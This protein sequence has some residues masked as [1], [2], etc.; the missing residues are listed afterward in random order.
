M[1]SKFTTLALA[2]LLTAA[3]CSPFPAAELET[4]TL[5]PRQDN[6]TEYCSDDAG[7]A[8]TVRPSD[9]TAFYLVQPGDNCLPIAQKFNNFTV[10]QLYRWNP[11]MGLGC[12]LQAYVPICIN[13]PWYKFTPPIQPAYGTHYTPSQDPVPIMPNIVS[14]CTEYELIAPGE[15]TDQLAA[16]NNITAQDFA[17]WNGN[18]TSGWQDYWA[19][20]KA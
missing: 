9:C 17:N 10:S 11:S 12:Y 8:C 13:T 5:M 14:N 16:E 6:C 3:T 15:R 4:N 20:V 7:C 1:F 18:A 2:A 19:C